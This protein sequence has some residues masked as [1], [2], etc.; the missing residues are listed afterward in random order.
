MWMLVLLGAFLGAMGSE[1]GVPGAARRLQALHCPPCEQVHCSSRRAL[2]LLCKGGVTT[3]VC[4]CC[5]VCA[6]AEG[7]TCGGTWDY[8][9]KCDQGLVCVSQGSDH[10]GIC[11][12]G[13]ESCQPECSREYCQ[14]HP[15]ETC[16][17]RSVS[18]EEAPCQGS[19]QHTSCS[20]CLLLNPP[21]C[22]QTC[23]RSDS[24]CLH[25]KAPWVNVQE[26]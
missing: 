4:G 14:A 16:S 8:L 19:C 13:P 5:P 12:T 25:R 17:A 1:D 3:G 10:E 15:L 24:A 11:Q 7:E 22:P 20:S 6:R 18:L 26:V 9:G 2:K 21:P 23:T